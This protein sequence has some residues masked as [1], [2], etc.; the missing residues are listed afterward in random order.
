MSE[1]EHTEEKISCSFSIGAP[2]G[3][4]LGM[5]AKAGLVCAVWLPLLPGVWGVG[6]EGRGDL[7]RLW[8]GIGGT[9]SH[10]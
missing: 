5:A 3:N 4:L 6:L 8:M 9:K 2:A 1:W 10:G 7:G